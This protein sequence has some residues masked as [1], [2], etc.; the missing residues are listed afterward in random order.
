MRVRSVSHPSHFYPCNPLVKSIFRGT[1]QPKLLYDSVT[2]RNR[3]HSPLLK[4][5]HVYLTVCFSTLCHGL[6]TC[7]DTE[8]IELLNV[9]ALY[10]VQISNFVGIQK[11]IMS[12]INAESHWRFLNIFITLWVA[13]FHRNCSEAHHYTVVFYPG[14][15]ILYQPDISYMQFLFVALEI[16]TVLI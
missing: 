6:Y 12:F 14:T 4:H 10:W 8:H 2:M 11:L 5:T 15:C 16:Y 9:E 7:F 1:F 13:I 3:Q